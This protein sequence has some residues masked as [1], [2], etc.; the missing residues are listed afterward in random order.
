[1]TAGQGPYG[2]A[3][4]PP[5]FSEESVFWNFFLS[6]ESLFWN[7]FFERLVG[8]LYKSFVLLRGFQQQPLPASLLDHVKGREKWLSPDFSGC[9]A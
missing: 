9:I 2:Q 4:S 7:S 3:R 1:M 6:E 5:P 8:Y